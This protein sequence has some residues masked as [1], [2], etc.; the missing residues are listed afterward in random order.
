V[1][2]ANF[3][4]FWKNHLFELKIGAVRATRG[5]VFGSVGTPA[6]ALFAGGCER[7]RNFM[8]AVWSEAEKC[9]TTVSISP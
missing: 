6:C 1:K 5:G 3:R 8:A 4:F 9:E 2:T 7:R